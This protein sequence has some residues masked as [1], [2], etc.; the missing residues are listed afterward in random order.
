MHGALMTMAMGAPAGGAGGQGGIGMMM[1]MIII[2]G[3]FYFMLIRPQQRKEKARRSM[4]DNV[5][6]G[7]RVMFSGGVLG[8]ITNVKDTTFV[9]KIA[10]NVKVEMARGAVNQVLEKGEKAKAD[11]ES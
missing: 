2:I 6:S 11:V 4:I 9:V 5:K 10:E 7:D 8:T 1:P 3:I